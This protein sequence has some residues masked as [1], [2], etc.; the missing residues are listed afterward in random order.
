[1]TTTHT[2]AEIIAALANSPD[3]EEVDLV[4]LAAEIEEDEATAPVPT[5]KMVT[6]KQVAFIARLVAE[7]D[8]TDPALTSAI[9]LARESVMSQTLTSRAASNLIDQLLAAPRKADTATTFDAPEGMHVLDEIT[10]KVQVAKNGSG[11][12]YAK[13]MTFD[14]DTERWTFVYAPGM[15]AR[16]SEATKMTG[17]LAAAFGALYGICCACGRD[18]T[19]ERSIEA[20]YGPI[21]AE[22]NG[23]PWG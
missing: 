2:D 16:L 11:R 19:D 23:W 1:M 8:T 17:E 12:K 21:C 14:P 10:Y 5:E 20:G 7:K 22:H 13:R 18:L 4:A 15:I 9:T 3:F 6:E